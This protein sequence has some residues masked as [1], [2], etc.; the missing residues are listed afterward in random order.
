MPD[1]W[2]LAIVA[3]SALIASLWDG[4]TPEHPRYGHG[5]PKELRPYVGKTYST[6]PAYSVEIPQDFPKLTPSIKQPTVSSFQLKYL[7]PDSPYL[8][9]GSTLL[10][11]SALKGP[12]ND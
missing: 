4:N 5:F 3:F 6:R 10:G 7:M 8:D 2:G 11:N 9:D 12:T 1:F